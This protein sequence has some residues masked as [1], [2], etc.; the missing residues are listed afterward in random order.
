MV[1]FGFLSGFRVAYSAGLLV[2]LVLLIVEHWL[3]R[4]GV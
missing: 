4:N 2:I 3:A 1:F